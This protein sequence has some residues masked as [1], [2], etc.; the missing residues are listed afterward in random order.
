[1]RL[2]FLKIRANEPEKISFMRAA[3]L[4]G[5]SLS[6]WARLILRREA[7]AELTKAG[8]PVPFLEEK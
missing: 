2:I 8:K 3:R 1:M 7:N 5:M 6:A 4:A